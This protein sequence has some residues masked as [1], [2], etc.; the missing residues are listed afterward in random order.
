MSWNMKDIM[1][2]W[3]LPLERS[4]PNSKVP[5]F[6]LHHDDWPFSF[7]LFWSEKT[8]SDKI[9]C[10]HWHRWAS[11]QRPSRLRSTKM[12]VHRSLVSFSSAHTQT[13]NWAA[14]VVHQNTCHSLPFCLPIAYGWRNPLLFI[15]R[16]LISLGLARNAKE[17]ADAPQ[18]QSSPELHFYTHTYIYISVSVHTLRLFVPFRAQRSI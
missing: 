15:H 17:R 13:H 2:S 8:S 11:L 14:S 7:L 1:R 5:E 10:I 16:S 12:C 9:I 18:R 4:C 6:S 3:Q